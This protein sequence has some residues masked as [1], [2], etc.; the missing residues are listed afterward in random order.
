[1]VGPL[2]LNALRVPNCDPLEGL[3][4]ALA[5][6]GASLVFASQV[7]AI[8]GLAARRRAQAALLFGLVWSAW[9]VRDL[10]FFAIAPPISAYNPFVGHVSGA[11]YDRV[12]QLDAR[13]AAYRWVNLAQLGL[14]WSGAT[15]AW[16]PSCG[17][18]RLARLRVAPLGRW[19][20]VGV[21]AAVVLTAYGHRGLMGYE[22]TRGHIEAT[23]GGRLDDGQ[24]SVLYDRLG[25]G[26][27]RARR[28]MEDIHFRLDQLGARLGEAPQ[29]P[30]RA[31]VYA[32]RAQ[33]RSLMGAGMVDIAKPWLGEIHLADVD[34]GEPVV[35]HELAHVVLA[36]H[37]DGLLGVPAVCG[38]LPHMALVEGA[39]VAI[40]W[41][42]GRLTPHQW[43]AAMRRAGLAP[44]M[45]EL[46]GPQGYFTQAAP[47][48][49]TLSGSLLRWLLERRGPGPFLRVYRDADFEAAYGEP[50]P[51]LVAAW[52]RFLDAIELPPGAV[53][54]ARQ[55]FS[56][57]AVLRQ[58]CSLELARL[59]AEASAL[60]RRGRLGDA[61]RVE[62]RAMA[63]T[64]RDPARH[65]PV[66]DLLARLAD[67]DGALAERDT[68]DGLS[69]VPEPALS[70]ADERLG[71]ALW[72]AGRVVEALAWYGRALDGPQPEDRQ[73]TVLVKQA[74]AVRA[75]LAPVLGPYLLGDIPLPV[76][77]LVEALLD[78]PGEPLVLYLVGRRLALEAS[79]PVAAALALDRALAA[80]TADERPVM[81]LVRREAHRL[82]GRA[83]VMAG[84]LD[85]AEASFGRALDLAAHDGR[86][87][88]LDDWVERIAWLRA[89]AASSE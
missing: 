88:E 31:Y 48:A 14:L 54:L 52:E 49:Y 56:G 84:R 43:S 50:L 33:R 27:A 28:L 63:F 87:V 67:A 1:M 39:A 20:V 35:L 5:G 30:V 66:L 55:R 36:E 16:D 76:L 71:D 42:G 57:R 89:R 32:S 11:I 46:L 51:R 15:L 78:D 80:I 73:R 82:R 72:R 81:T 70:Y 77:R 10:A 41:S 12:V 25:V 85:E 4:F 18:L 59:D 45:D 65:L 2:L 21:L 79:Q 23:L 37:S 69:D 40:E 38:L 3:A 58:T 9:V 19:A 8:A 60:A 13:L 34:V 47:V 26:E 17:R 83:L 86:R 62:R 44:R 53:E 61:L 29:R 74:V 64:P 7:G 24:V 6:P 22:H 68:L 75:D